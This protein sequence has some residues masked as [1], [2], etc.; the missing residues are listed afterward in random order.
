[1]VTLAS[2]WLP[3]LLS[4]VAVFIASSLV[5]MVLKYHDSDYP[6]LPSEAQFRAGLRGVSYNL[7]ARRRPLLCGGSQRYRARMTRAITILGIETS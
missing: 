3:I 7:F 6:G 2:L 1:M 5:H 4:A